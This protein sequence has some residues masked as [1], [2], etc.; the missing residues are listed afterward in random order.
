MGPDP[1]LLNRH[2]ASRGKIT[3]TGFA[4]SSHDCKSI[5][6]S[7]REAEAATPSSIETS[8]GHWVENLFVCILTP[9]HVDGSD[10]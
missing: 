1:L 4:R 3:V 6:A 7:A 10:I 5:N 2:S 9:T 8:K